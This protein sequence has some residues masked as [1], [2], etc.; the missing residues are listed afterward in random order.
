MLFSSCLFVWLSLSAL[1]KAEQAAPAVQPLQPQDDDFLVVRPPTGI[2]AW[3]V[4][5]LFERQ[6]RVCTDPAYSTQCAA[7]LANGNCCGTDTYCCPDNLAFCCTKGDTCQVVKGVESC[8]PPDRE[9]CDGRQCAPLGYVCCNAYNHVC[10]PGQDCC[11]SLCCEAGT[12]CCGDTCCDAGNECCPGANGGNGGCC[13]P[14]NICCGDS[15]CDPAS[16]TC[17]NGVCVNKSTPRTTGVARTTV[18]MTA[19]GVGGGVETGA[20]V[21]KGWRGGR[22]GVMA[23]P[24][25]VGLGV[26]VGF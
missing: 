19:A 5:K 15:C 21:V 23:V 24:L 2:G 7:V 12:K 10:G 16:Q 14:G 1:A 22:V 9:T 25:A 20:A 4:P 17:S 13:W 18:T 8:C 11:K 6:E 3:P 26:G